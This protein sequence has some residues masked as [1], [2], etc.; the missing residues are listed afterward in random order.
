[1]KDKLNEI[2][3]LLEE[4]DQMIA[5]YNDEIGTLDNAAIYVANAM[6][7]IRSALDEQERA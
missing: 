7:E 3:G 4:A 2:M 5:D 6:D 1:M